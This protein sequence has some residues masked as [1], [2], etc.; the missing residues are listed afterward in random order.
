MSTCADARYTIMFAHIAKLEH[1][2]SAYDE[3][4][5]IAVNYNYWWA[6]QSE[7]KRLLTVN[8]SER[9]LGGF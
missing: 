1:S 8:G 5:K 7:K 9:Y 4:D 6:Q 3:Q 2:R